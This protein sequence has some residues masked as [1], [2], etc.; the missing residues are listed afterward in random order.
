M[1]LTLE[2]LTEWM[3][4]I[5]TPLGVVKYVLITGMKDTVDIRTVQKIVLITGIHCNILFS[6]WPF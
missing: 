3:W 5:R 6:L 2:L 1:S 4:V